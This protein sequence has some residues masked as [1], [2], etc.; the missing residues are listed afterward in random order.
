MPVLR[1]MG[2]TTAPRQ[3]RTAT[4]WA[5][6]AATR[7]DTVVARVMRPKAAGMPIRW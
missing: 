6:Q 3:P 1:R 5:S 4:A 2:V 7:R